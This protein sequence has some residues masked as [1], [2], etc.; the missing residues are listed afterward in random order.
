M[1]KDVNDY[2]GNYHSDLLHNDNKP[3]FRCKAS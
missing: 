2:F 3:F 1:G